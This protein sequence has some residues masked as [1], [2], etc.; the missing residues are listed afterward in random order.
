MDKKGKKMGEA[1]EDERDREEALTELRIDHRT[2]R[3]GGPL[4][5]CPFCLYE[6]YIQRELERVTIVYTK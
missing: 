2:N 3:C 6:E 5:C 1:A 4:S